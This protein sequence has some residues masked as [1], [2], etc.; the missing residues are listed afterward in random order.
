MDPWLDSPSP[1]ESV[2]HDNPR[3]AHAVLDALSEVGRCV[4]CLAESTRLSD[5]A[6]RSVL[7]GMR[8]SV[9]D[10]TG[11]CGTCGTRRLIYRL[12]V[13]RSNPV[14]GGTLSRSWMRS[15]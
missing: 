13:A 10:D 9:V 3:V 6:L 7:E 15:T 8:T 12:G 5:L 14:Q 4:P 2:A 11:F 1:P